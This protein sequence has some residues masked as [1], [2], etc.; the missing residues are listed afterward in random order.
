MWDKPIVMP[1]NRYFPKFPKLSYL[2]N[3][4]LRIWTLSGGYLLW[5]IKHWEL[6]MFI[7]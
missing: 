6:R 2:Q 7:H 3:V 1:M 5:L 4:V